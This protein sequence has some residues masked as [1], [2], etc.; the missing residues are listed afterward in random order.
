[1]ELRDESRTFHPQTGLGELATVLGR[2][3]RGSYRETAH[4]DFR[5]ETAGS[6]RWTSSPKEVR[7]DSRGQ[8]RRKGKDEEVASELPRRGQ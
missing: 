2:R 1:V 5:L 6:S 3:G 7:Q 8:M 4:P